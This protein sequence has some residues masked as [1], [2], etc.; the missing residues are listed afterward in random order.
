MKHFWLSVIAVTALSG[1]LPDTP[2]T[3]TNNSASPIESVVIFGSGFSHLFGTIAPGQ[4]VSAGV[5][6]RGE[7]G[8]GVA[9]RAGTRQVRT[10][11]QGYLEGGGAYK[12]RVV[13]APDLSVQVTG[14]LKY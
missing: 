1:C 7:S 13:I 6:L 5:D 11:P 9:F 4:S 2:V 3:V 14:D 10:Q 12:V 8:L